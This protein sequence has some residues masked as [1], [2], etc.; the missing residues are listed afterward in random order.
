MKNLYRKLL[1]KIERGLVMMRT[2]K[3]NKSLKKSESRLHEKSCNESIFHA[4][5]PQNAS[6]PLNFK[7]YSLHK[8]LEKEKVLDHDFK[9]YEDFDEYEY[10]SHCS[11]GYTCGDVS[12]VKIY[13]DFD[14][15]YEETKEEDENIFE[16]VVFLNS[17]EIYEEDIHDRYEV[18]AVRYGN[19]ITRNRFRPRSLKT[20]C[21]S[22]I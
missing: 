16:N 7:I 11:S 19:D 18:V 9:I 13:E 12:G 14:Q 10:L 17:L 21:S 15:F 1:I 6:T 3:Q 4:A 2:R 22:F 8:N 20:G 5:Q